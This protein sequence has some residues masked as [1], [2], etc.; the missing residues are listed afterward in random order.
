MIALIC[1]YNIIIL[2]ECAS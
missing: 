1:N 2:V